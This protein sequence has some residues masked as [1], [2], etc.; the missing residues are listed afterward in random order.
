MWLKHEGGLAQS[1]LQWALD[2]E[3]SLETLTSQI[4]WDGGEGASTWTTLSRAFLKGEQRNR[5]E[6]GQGV[7]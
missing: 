5:A 2:I 1:W 6:A 7:E 3:R 4:L